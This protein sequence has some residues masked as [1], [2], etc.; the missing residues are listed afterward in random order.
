MN[1]YCSAIKCSEAWTGAII[2]MNL[3]HTVERKNSEPNTTQ[4][5]IEMKFPERYACSGGRQIGS[6]PGLGGTSRRAEGASRNDKK[7]PRNRSW[8]VDGQCYKFTTAV[9]EWVNFFPFKK[10]GK[11][12]MMK[13]LLSWPLWSV[14][15]SHGVHS[16][17]WAT[18]T[19]IPLWHALVLQN[20]K[21]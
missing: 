1:G 19:A 16:H 18:L 20:W 7:R 14:V 9:L 2:S 10:C 21:I 3:E 15:L 13:S 4:G 11:R 12:H 8:G 5:S 17:W 6:C